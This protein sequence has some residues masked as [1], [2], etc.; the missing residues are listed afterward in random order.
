MISQ[1]RE[2]SGDNG[3]IAV[4]ALL[5]AQPDTSGEPRNKKKIK[6]FDGDSVAEA[7]GTNK[8]PPDP[9]CPSTTLTNL[10]E[11]AGEDVT[12]ASIQTEDTTRGRE[13]MKQEKKKHEK[14][15]KPQGE[16]TLPLPK[17]SASIQEKRS[18]VKGAH[19]NSASSG[20]QGA[21]ESVIP[22]PT[23]PGMLHVSFNVSSY[24][25]IKRNG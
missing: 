20:A 22:A 19:D 4:Q 24:S 18:K 25:F 14:K 17:P 11:R 13:N 5:N 10:L 7:G 9:P 8:S 16:S 12:M 23:E 2:S 3:D 1:A 6:V 21:T 15:Q